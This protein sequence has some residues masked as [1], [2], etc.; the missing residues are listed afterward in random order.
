MSIIKHIPN[1]ITCL[2][3]ISGT[4]SII[5]AFNCDFRN[6]FL[7]MIAASVFDFLDGFAARGLKAYSDIGKELDSLCDTVSFGLAP[8]LILYNYLKTVPDIP[9]IIT[10]IPILIAVFSV[11]RLAKFNI[12]SRQ[13]HSFIGL[14][15]PACALFVGAMIHYSTY[16]PEFNKLLENYYVL[17]LLSIILSFLLVSELNFFSLKFQNFHWKENKRS[18]SFLIIA[19]PTLAIGIIFKIEWSGIVMLIFLLYIIW[20]IAGDLI[21]LFSKKTAESAH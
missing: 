21:S 13:S 12:D 11:L 20:N 7:L 3:I 18:F 16:S 6:A 8:S 4:F 5:F 9:I 17:P 2:N 15:T 1:A 19:I 10:F 14:P